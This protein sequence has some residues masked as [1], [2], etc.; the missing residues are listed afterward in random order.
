MGVTD[1]TNDNENDYKYNALPKN[2]NNQ[3][4]HID[5]AEEVLTKEEKSQE[6]QEMDSKHEF[7]PGVLQVTVHEAKDLQNN[8]KFELTALKY[9]DRLNV[10][11]SFLCLA[12][13]HCQHVISRCQ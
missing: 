1:D 10:A 7:K 3:N 4:E 8:D 11:L 13:H 12:Q 9:L 5:N 6:P 2:E